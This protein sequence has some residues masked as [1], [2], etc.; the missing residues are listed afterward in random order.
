MAVLKIDVSTDWMLAMIVDIPA[1]HR[2]QCSFF[3]LAHNTKAS[4]NLRH[5][6]SGHF[7]YSS[8]RVVR[9]SIGIFRSSSIL[10]RFIVVDRGDGR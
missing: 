5:R 10:R 8:G 2:S 3:I 6:A 9:I 1:I 7:L 4:F